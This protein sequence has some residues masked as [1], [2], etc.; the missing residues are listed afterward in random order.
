MD[1]Q[2]RFLFRVSVF[3]LLWLLL[4]NGA[5]N[6]WVIG[7]PMVLLA[8]TVSIKLLP[9]TPISF[10]ALLNFIP[11]FLW[12]SL[13][14]GFDVAKR[15]FYPKVAISPA[16]FN[17]RWRLPLGLSRVFMANTVSLLPGTLSVELNKEY[18]QIHVLDDSID[19]TSVLMLVEKRVAE[20]FK[21]NLSAM[22]R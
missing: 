22:E 18:L 8:T 13:L 14:G 2:I 9:E 15:V 11:F 3:S 4:V 20:I 1:L 7:V 21:L 5:M 16:I 17:Y 6:S 10:I 19:F 12:H